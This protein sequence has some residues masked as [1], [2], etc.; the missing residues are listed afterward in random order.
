[1]WVLLVVRGVSMLFFGA[2]AVD[3]STD[4]MRHGVVKFRVYA[5]FRIRTEMM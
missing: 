1:M 3:A 5:T 4:S 2:S